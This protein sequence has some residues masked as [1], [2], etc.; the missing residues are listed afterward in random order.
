[1]VTS[2]RIL[3]PVVTAFTVL[4]SGALF[5]PSADAAGSSSSATVLTKALLTEALPPTD[6]VSVADRRRVFNAPA[7]GGYRLDW[8]LRWAEACG[9]PAADAFCVANGFQEAEGYTPAHD[10]GARSPTL[11]LSTRQICNEPFCDGFQSITC[12]TSG[13]GSGGGGGNARAAPAMVFVNC[14]VSPCVLGVAHPGYAV[15]GNQRYAEGWRRFN[16]NPY[17]LTDFANHE[18]AWRFAC[19]IHYSSPQHNAPDI[20]QRR[21]DCAR[22]CNGNPRCP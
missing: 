5:S 8:C 4:V 7:V 9:K 2:M 20:V 16:T 10:I 15:P 21:V 18:D 12:R 11:V 19:R 6:I 1:M 22:L 13:G 14:S 17:P 3:A